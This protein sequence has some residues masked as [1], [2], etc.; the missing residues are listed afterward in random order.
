MMSKPLATPTFTHKNDFPLLE[1]RSPTAIRPKISQHTPQKLGELKITS[2]TPKKA[3]DNASK[4][5]TERFKQTMI[6]ESNTEAS[7]AEIWRLRSQE[8][9]GDYLK[10][11]RP[12]LPPVDQNTLSLRQKELEMAAMKSPAKPDQTFAQSMEEIDSFKFLNEELEKLKKIADDH[13][14]DQ[15]HE[16]VYLTLGHQ[17]NERLFQVIADDKPDIE[18]QLERI[19]KS[20]PR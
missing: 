10:F 1:D 6:T 14:E 9:I 4:L 17:I 20:D 11:S 7:N 16:A 12:N 3:E 2:S 18:M 8:S 5:D 13:Q 15:F 19:V